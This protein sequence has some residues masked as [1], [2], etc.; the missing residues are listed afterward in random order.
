MVSRRS[1]EPLESMFLSKDTIAQ[2]IKFGKCYYCSSCARISEVTL[3]GI[4][5]VIVKLSGLLHVHMYVGRVLARKIF[6]EGW[7]FEIKAYLSFLA[8]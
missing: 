4:S 2:S 8:H 3:A 6:K 1:V 7:W 5:D